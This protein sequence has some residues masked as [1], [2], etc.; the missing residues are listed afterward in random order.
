MHITRLATF[1]FQLQAV[2]DQ[3]GWTIGRTMRE[4]GRYGYRAAETATYELSPAVFS[5]M[6]DAGWSVSNLY[7]FPDFLSCDPDMEIDRI[8]T[9]VDA[10]S[11]SKVMVIPR[12]NGRCGEELRP[13][14]NAIGKL[15]AM[16]DERDIPLMMEVF[17]L[18][19]PSYATVSGMQSYLD[20]VPDLKV[21]FDTGNLVY[22][23]DDCL[24]TYRRWESRIAH[25]HLK[26]WSTSDDHGPYVF[27]AMDGRDIA[28]VPFDG[29][30]LRIRDIVSSLGY[31]GTVAMEQTPCRDQLAAEIAS[32]R[33]VAELVEA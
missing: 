28:P 33:A 5:E 32:A 7:E 25:M 27:R 17:V 26:D 20:N 2:A 12:E 31:S 6:Q 13:V 1:F 14:W 4:L 23:G 18:G 16:L 30:F 22:G 21:C 29:G 3:R 24:A 10:W 9:A 11:P 19:F 15:A 8:M